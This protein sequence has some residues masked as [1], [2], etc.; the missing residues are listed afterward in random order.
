[1]TCNFIPFCYTLRKCAKKALG[2]VSRTYTLTLL[3]SCKVLED[4]FVTFA[5]TSEL[6]WHCYICGFRENYTM[7]ILVSLLN[8]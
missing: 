6:K 4:A 1:M 5:A 2:P 8:T 7:M 3:T